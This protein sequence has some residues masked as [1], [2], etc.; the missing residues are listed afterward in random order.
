MCPLNTW[1]WDVHYEIHLSPSNSF[2][3]KAMAEKWSQKNGHW[4]LENSEKTTAMFL[5]VIVY[6]NAINLFWFLRWHFWS[7]FNGP[8]CTI[9]VAGNIKHHG[10]RRENVISSATTTT[11]TTKSECRRIKD[12]TD[13]WR[14]TCWCT[15]FAR[16]KPTEDRLCI[17]SRIRSE[18]EWYEV[19]GMHTFC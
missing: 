17:Y 16:W 19:K 14:E 3:P 4:S 7:L 6:M 5:S 15:N 9:R 11:T 13:E 2:W 12:E 8:S 10:S 1:E 18:S